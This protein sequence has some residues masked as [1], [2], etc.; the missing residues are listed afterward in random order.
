M[1][2]RTSVHKLLN[3]S[4]DT[5]VF[6]TYRTHVTVAANILAGD[7]DRAI[8]SNSTGVASR[9]STSTSFRIAQ[10]WQL[11]GFTNDLLPMTPLVHDKFCTRQLHHLKGNDV[12]IGSDKRVEYSSQGL[13]LLRSHA[14]RA[15]HSLSRGCSPD[16][17]AKLR[18]DVE[19]VYCPKCEG[20]PLGIAPVNHGGRACHDPG[21]SSKHGVDKQATLFLQSYGGFAG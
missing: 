8:R 21:P 13:L 20:T 2:Y 4:L 12:C 11:Y 3:A 10:R 1:H 9:V 17:C 6:S 5:F 18:I 16:H 15:R 14:R 19:I 7:H